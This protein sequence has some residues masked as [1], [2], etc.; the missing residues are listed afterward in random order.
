[1][2]GMEKTGTNKPLVVNAEDFD[3]LGE[4][5]ADDAPPSYYPLLF[6]FKWFVEG[7]NAPSI[8]RNLKIAGLDSREGAPSTK[9]GPR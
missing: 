7:G 9:P 6:C 4:R 3:C 8:P 1:L 2:H 5:H